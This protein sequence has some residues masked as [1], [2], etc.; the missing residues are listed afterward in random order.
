MVQQ[1]L[2]SRKGAFKTPASYLSRNGQ[3]GLQAGVC[4]L[5]AT[6]LN[7]SG[8]KHLCVGCKAQ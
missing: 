6:C 8:L 1:Y 2:P 7:V 3:K 5:L 4:P